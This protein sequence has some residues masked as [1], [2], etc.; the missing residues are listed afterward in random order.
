M[1]T[2]YKQSKALIENELD[3]I[4]QSQKQKGSEV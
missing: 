3:R 2:F 4:T 1:T